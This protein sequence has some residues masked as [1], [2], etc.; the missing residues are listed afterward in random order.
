[1]LALT[2]EDPPERWQ[3]L[4]EV[5]AA[6]EEEE[7]RSAE[8]WMRECVENAM[9][10]DEEQELWDESR[11]KVCGSGTPA[12]EKEKRGEPAHPTLGSS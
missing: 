8:R 11:G 6:L 12:L 9:D 2:D 7:E 3:S 4:C 5:Y 10:T 1:M